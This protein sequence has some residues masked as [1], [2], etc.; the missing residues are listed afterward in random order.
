MEYTDHGGGCCG[1]AHLWLFDEEGIETL[2]AR[3]RQ[4]DAIAGGNRLLEVVLSERQVA[5]QPPRERG[6]LGHL[7]LQ[8]VR[9]AGGWPTILRERG[10][11]L[12][13]R[14]RNSNSGQLCYVFHR[15]PEWQSLR[16]EDLPFDWP[17]AG[18]DI[19]EPAPVVRPP[20]PPANA[21]PIVNEVFALFA[22]G[23]VRGPFDY[24]AE[25]RQAYPRVARYR[26]RKIYADA[27][28]EIEDARMPRGN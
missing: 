4:H 28:V 25:I 27:R 12:V 14:F 10:F 7:V 13:S 6:G 22:D 2:D 23:R 19:V 21:D 8:E 24:V 15:V 9:D 18:N 5:P 11:R 20:A 1:I 3:I 26:R 16:N 17:E